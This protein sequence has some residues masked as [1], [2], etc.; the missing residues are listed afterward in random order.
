[1][2]AW[3]VRRDPRA[4][5]HLGGSAGQFGVRQPRL[6]QPGN[7]IVQRHPASVRRE[8]H[9]AKSLTRGTQCVCG[10]LKAMHRLQVPANVYKL[11]KGAV[12]RPNLHVENVLDPAAER[13]LPIHGFEAMPRFEG[14]F[15]LCRI[16]C[17]HHTAAARKDS[18]VEQQGLHAHLRA[19]GVP[20]V[21]PAV[22]EA[23]VDLPYLRG[24]CLPPVGLPIPPRHEIMR[25][26]TRYRLPVNAFG[27]APDPASYSSVRF[28]L[29]LHCRGNA[30]LAPVV[31]RYP[32]ALEG[33]GHSAASGIAGPRVARVPCAREPSSSGCRSCG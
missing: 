4:T 28:R 22:R 8:P 23:C 1:M 17:Q 19:G 27:H 6:Q 25:F 30:C 16:V 33:A 7:Q 12:S 18:V 9:V 15:L 11:A 20:E 32:R 5:K 29:P 3:R 26:E 31:R 13:V 2:H 24:A 21:F 14:F 10:P